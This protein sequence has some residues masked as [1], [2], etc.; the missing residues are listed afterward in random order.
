[1]IEM[2]ENCKEELEGWKKYPDQVSRD[3]VLKRI[4]V[5]LGIESLG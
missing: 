5:F 2:L 1:M 4:Y 3:D